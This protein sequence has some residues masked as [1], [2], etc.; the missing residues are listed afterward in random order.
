MLKFL[1]QGCTLDGI[2]E[3]DTG[4]SLGLPHEFT[5][6]GTQLGSTSTALSEAVFLH[7]GEKNL[8][9]QMQGVFCN[10]STTFLSPLQ[11]SWALRKP[12]SQHF[13]KKQAF[14]SPF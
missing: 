5:S 14:E 10:S 6:T 13:S 12:V 4:P 1:Y 9:L 8:T 7:K 2:S 11:C 3:D